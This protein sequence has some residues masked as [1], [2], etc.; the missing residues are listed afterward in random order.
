M[1]AKSNNQESDPDKTRLFTTEENYNPVYL[2]GTFRRLLNGMRDFTET[3]FTTS[4]SQGLRMS[5]DRYQSAKDYLN[6]F[7][8]TMLAYQEG[9]Q[10]G[11][12]SPKQQQ[13]ILVMVDEILKGK[14]EAVQFQVNRSGN[15]IRE[16]FSSKV[17]EL[18]PHN[19]NKTNDKS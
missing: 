11:T 13:E 10:L 19:K 2:I 4:G 12:L 5:K 7:E 3:V 1:S 16:V 8:V 18:Q 9:N 14:R 17:F 15:A 6:A